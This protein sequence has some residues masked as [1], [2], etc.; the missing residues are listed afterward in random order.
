MMSHGAEGRATMASKVLGFLVESGMLYILIGVSSISAHKP[1][2]VIINL[3][4]VI[5]L[6]SVFIHL[7]FGTLGDILL[8]VGVQLAVRTKYS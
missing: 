5:V 8:P 4:Q 6:V 1:D 3:S 2:R 7:S